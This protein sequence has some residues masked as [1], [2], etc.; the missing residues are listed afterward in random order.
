MTTE[1]AEVTAADSAIAIDTAWASAPTGAPGP[2]DP[3]NLRKLGTVD[4]TLAS[5]CDVDGTVAGVPTTPS[6]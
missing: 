6:H 5:V 2:A 1:G 3:T 4:N